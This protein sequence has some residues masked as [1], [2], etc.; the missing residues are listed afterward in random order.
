MRKYQKRLLLIDGASGKLLQNEI[1]A[2]LNG[3]LDVTV[4][5]ND[6]KDY[7]ELKNIFQDK[8][9]YVNF[10]KTD[11]LA[12]IKELT[13]DNLGYHIIKLR[14]GPKIDEEVISIATSDNLQ[15]RLK[16]IAQTGVG[17]NHIDCKAATKRNVF[18]T[19]T[20][21]TN[22]NAVAEF[23]I[24]QMLILARNL[25]YH[26][27]KCNAGTWS[28]RTDTYFELTGKTLGIIGIGNV[29]AALI[30]KATAL[31]MK[32]VAY[33]ML[34]PT[35]KMSTLP[36]TMISKFEEFLAQADCVSVHVPLTN[37]TRN[38]ISHKE[39]RLMKKG[40]LL[41]NTARGGVVDEEAL[42]KELKRKNRRIA[43]AA[44][45]V[46]INELSA[47]VSPLIGLNNVILTP[48]IA[49]TTTEALMESIKILAQ[50]I[51]SILK[52][53]YN[54]PIVNRELINF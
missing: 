27:N 17:I 16:V 19:N 36:Y 37:T 33:S 31:G 18:I 13:K 23:V 34:N 6:T 42:A 12:L 11:K 41:I 38:L 48:H 44:V 20:P 26:I 7:L 22:S 40:S 5:I 15:S 43:G 53:N 29:A 46:H 1:S 2:F 3:D 52:G 21:S 24:A 9:N 28:Q 35:K 32:V 45:D 51:V 50:N 54:V 10:D 47:Y 14:L 30:P 49:G 8:I 25:I 39:L 4:N